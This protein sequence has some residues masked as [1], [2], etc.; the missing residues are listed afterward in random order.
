M[1]KSTIVLLTL[2]AFGGLIAGCG[3]NGPETVKVRGIVSLDGKPVEDA[4]VGF[5]PK[6]GGRPAMGT[7]DAS[8]QF[9]LTTF[10]PGDGAV[11]GTHTVTV[12]KIRS[13][14]QQVD[15]STVPA[16]SNA[17]PLSGPTAPGAIKI[18]WVV[19]PKYADPK[20]SGFTVD[21]KRG[22]EPVTL[23]LKSK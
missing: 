6:D 21:V 7:T 3:S 9:T 4:T 23:D 17:M 15:A 18:Q 2:L 14:G 12:S 16:G 5:T 22:M 11:V 13:S 20:T 8:G 10:T 1:Q 19:P